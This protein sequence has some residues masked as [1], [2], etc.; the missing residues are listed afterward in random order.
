[1]AEAAADE[2]GEPPAP[3]PVV[4]APV[5]VQPHHHYDAD[6]ENLAMPEPLEETGAQPQPLTLQAVA[7]QS[8]Q[9]AVSEEAEAAPTRRRIFAALCFLELMANFDAGVLPATV[10][11]LMTEFDLGYTEGG[12]LGALVYLGLTTG[13]PVAGYLLTNVSSQ[14]KLL[15]AAVAANGAAV[16]LFG[17]AFNRPMLYLSRFLI[18]FTQAP[19]IVYLPVWVDEFAH[20]DHQTMWMAFLQAA[21]AL[22]IMTGYVTAGLLV[23]YAGTFKCKAIDAEHPSGL[24]H[25]QTGEACYNSMWRVTLFIQAVAIWAYI[26]FFMF[27]KGRH[28][29]A[30]GSKQGRERYRAEK[31]LDKQVTSMDIDQLGTGIEQDSCIQPSPGSDHGGVTSFESEDSAASA[32]PSAAIRGSI[33]QLHSAAQDSAD[34]FAAG[35]AS[36]ATESFAGLVGSLFEDHSKCWSVCL[37]VSAPTVGHAVCCVD[38]ADNQ[39]LLSAKAQLRAILSN[40]LFLSLT[41]SLCGL[42]FVVTGI[43]FWIT[44]YLTTPVSEGGIGADVGLVV[45]CFALSSLT[46]PTLGVFFGG[47][48]I[49]RHGGYANTTGEQHGRPAQLTNYAPALN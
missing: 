11:H 47:Y 34:T 37:S 26:P 44:D 18:G 35:M 22:G 12:T 48:Y 36:V 43:Q 29:N 14:R 45:I 20:V 27:A 31:F 25:V 28:V 15:M 13:A 9:A 38:E 40:R 39:Q 41:L 8:K 7:Q 17:A 49:D 33:K 30:Q 46:G 3:A 24:D 23:T 2:K 4:T 1:M 5:V 21:V 10:T 32:S 16:F 42:Y 19:I 6:E